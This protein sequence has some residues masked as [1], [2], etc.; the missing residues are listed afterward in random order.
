M[1]R[2]SSASG[3]RTRTRGPELS[4]SEIGPVTI[5]V[6]ETDMA[7]SASCVSPDRNDDALT[8]FQA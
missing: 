5:T 2:R 6:P 4:P 3:S 7:N 1:T 8:A